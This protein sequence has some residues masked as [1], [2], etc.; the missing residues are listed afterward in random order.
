LIADSSMDERFSGTTGTTKAEVC[1]PM[2]IGERIIGVIAAESPTPNVFDENDL[3]LLSTLA[4]QV[5]ATVERARL[6]NE[7]EQ[8]L[9]EISDLFELTNLM[10]TATSEE[11]LQELIVSGT[12]RLLNA[13]GGS[14]QIL[15]EDEQ[16]LRLVATH[17]L[18]GVGAEIPRTVGGLSWDAINSGESYV[19]ENVHN[20][21]RIRLPELVREIRGAIVAP[22][23]TPTNN[24]GT[25][26]VGFDSPEL[27][28]E[29][30]LHLVS[31]IAN[32]AAH[33]M[34]RQRLYEQTL[35]QA[36]FLAL[37]LREL[38][39]SYQA[40]LLA[41]SAAL[42][43]RDSETEGH[44]RRVMKLAIAIGQKLKLS[45][46]ELTALERGALLHDVGKIGI[47][48]N[49]LLKPGPLTPKEREL[50]NRHPEMGHEMLQGIP[51]LQDVLPIVLYHQEMFDG[52]GYPY[53]MKG[54]EIP[55]GARIFAVAD[56]Y[57]AMTSSRPYREAMPHEVA[58]KEIERCAGSQFDPMVVD[59]FKQIF[60]DGMPVD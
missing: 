56:T 19:V 34:Q 30:Q 24:L 47:S 13:R 1:V 48:D 31:T 17:G 50:M 8:R 57:D 52:S 6:L 20:D 10:R 55:L 44:S 59:A 37:A 18:G 42:D 49:I 16:V 2:K 35:G 29:S 33:A 14:L 36:E 12:V 39:S 41:L 27:P 3:R 60:E 43:A 15:S 28:T 58:I 21:D 5:A 25:L 22:L 32:L 7:T 40:T 11:R 54:E 9:T 4:H 51:F 23:R 46:G 26:F 45:P 38:Q 53:G